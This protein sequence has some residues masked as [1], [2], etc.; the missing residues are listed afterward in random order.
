MPQITKDYWALENSERQP[1][2]DAS[3]ER[4][5]DLKEKGSA[6]IRVQRRPDAAP[7][8]QNALTVVP[9]GQR[10]YHPREQYAQ[11]Q[12]TARADQLSAFVQN[13]GL[14]IVEG[15]P[16]RM[17]S[18]SGLNN[19]QVSEPLFRAAPHVFCIALVIASMLLQAF[20]ASAADSMS[21]WVITYSAAAKQR[22]YAF[23]RGAN[24]TGQ[25]SVGLYVPLLG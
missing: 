8:E 16:A 10:K 19:R 5:A 18:V 4:P 3:R 14:K 6:S 15:T 22:I 17:E 2:M 12:G 9:Q 25:I 20:A 24:G 23:A 7:L 11:Q 21:P 1:A 13:H